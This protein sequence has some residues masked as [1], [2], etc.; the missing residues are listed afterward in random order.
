MTRALVRA[1]PSV[2]CLLFAACATSNAASNVPPGGASSIHGD[3]SSLPDFELTTIDGDQLRLS[4][5]LGRSVVV[6]AFWDTWCE[7][8]KSELPQLDRIYRVHKGEGL[9]VLSIA[10]DDPTSV[11]QVAP[12]VKQSGFTFPVL[13][14]T[15]TRAASLYNVH[16]SAPYTVVIARNGKID[17]EKAGYEPGA[18]KALEEEIVTLLRQPKT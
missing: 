1:R 12:F 10:M 3:S 5:Y 14:D 7:P 17:H 9:I 18:E 6:L 4:D 2:L 8:C 11:A 13:L 16:K 15:N